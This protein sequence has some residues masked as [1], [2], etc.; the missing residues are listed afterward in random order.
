MILW[1]HNVVVCLDHKGI[2]LEYV[3]ESF[4]DACYA[5][6]TGEAVN[7]SV[8]VVLVRTNPVIS[9][10]STLAAVVSS[11]QSASRSAFRAFEAAIIRRSVAKSFTIFALCQLFM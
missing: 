7:P 8:A 9:H 2:T 10:Y 11:I 3:L 5:V 4:A 1:L 6:Q